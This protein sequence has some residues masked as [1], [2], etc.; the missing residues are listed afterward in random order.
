MARI[1][2][3]IAQFFFQWGAT[4]RHFGIAHGLNK[5]FER[6][7]YYFGRAYTIDPTFRQARLNRAI[8]LGRELGRGPE[9]LA[10]FDALLAEDS[11]YMEARFNRAQQRQE[12]GDYA[13]ALADWELYLLHPDENYKD[14]AESTVKLL[15]EVL[16][17]PK[18]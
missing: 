3:L 6:A 16:L 14:L 18:S 8:M 1:R 9:A 12:M 11:L 15:R 2:F 4:H 10:E 13:G 17:P 5:E 7:A